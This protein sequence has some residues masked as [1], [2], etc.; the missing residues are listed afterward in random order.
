MQLPFALCL[1]PI[2]FSSCNSDKKVDHSQHIN[3]DNKKE[4]NAGV[5]LE[6]LLKP[7]NQ[8]VISTIPITPIK[9]EQVVVEIDALG[10]VEYDTRLIGNI[11]ARIN[12]R[13]E[14]LYVRYKYQYI[15]KGQKIM[16]IYSPEGHHCR[17]SRSFYIM[18]RSTG[19]YFTIFAITAKRFCHRS[20]SGTG[21][22]GDQW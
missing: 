13:I 15:K 3:S 7:T 8:F 11:S 12:G 9:K 2:V 4:L 10:R 6:S 19:I 1:L 5:Q 16:D 21:R 22:R 18:G 17:I 14:K 20:H